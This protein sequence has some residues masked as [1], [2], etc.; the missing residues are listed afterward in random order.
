MSDPPLPVLPL[1]V[2][3]LFQIPD[4]TTA[5]EALALSVLSYTDYSRKGMRNPFC[6]DNV[7]VRIGAVGYDNELVADRARRLWARSLGEPVLRRVFT[8]WVAQIETGGGKCD[9]DGRLA[10]EAIG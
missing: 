6:E 2:V 8:F 1:R 5:P 10:V 4:G 7:K 3:R 9:T